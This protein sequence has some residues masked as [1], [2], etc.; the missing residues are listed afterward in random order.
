MLVSA[1]NHTVSHATVKDELGV[2]SQVFSIEDHQEGL[3]YVVAVHI[4]RELDHVTA[5]GVDHTHKV[6]VTHARL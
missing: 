1:D 4:H 6:Q 5:Q 3:N 2:L